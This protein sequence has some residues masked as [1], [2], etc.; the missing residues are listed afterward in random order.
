MTWTWSPNKSPWARDQMLYDAAGKMNS[1]SAS[2][3][4]FRLSLKL[5]KKFNQSFQ[6]SMFILCLKAIFLL[7]LWEII[8]QM[9]SGGKLYIWYLFWGLWVLTGAEFRAKILCGFRN[10]EWRKN[11]NYISSH[12]WE[13]KNYIS[14]RFEVF[15]TFYI[16]CPE[17]LKVNNNA[18]KLQFTFWIWLHWSR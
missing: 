14:G 18:W 5:S 12:F 7:F 2:L 4:P 9:A 17:M 16:F 6:N 13:S 15:L 1:I 10:S 11:K 3:I 8:L